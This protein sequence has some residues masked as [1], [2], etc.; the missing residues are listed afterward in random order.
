MFCIPV[1]LQEE[2]FRP[3]Y[4]L[5][6]TNEAGEVATHD[7]SPLPTH[8]NVSSEKEDLPSMYSEKGRVLPMYNE[9]VSTKPTRTRRPKSILV[10]L[11]LIPLFMIW[12]YIFFP[13]VEFNPSSR[14]HEYEE[15]DSTIIASCKSY[16][17]LPSST[18]NNRLS[19]LSDILPQEM[20]WISEP[21]PSTY[22]F[23]GSFSEEEWFLSERPFLISIYQNKIILLTPSFESLR[24]KLI[25]IPEEL[26]DKVEWVEWNEDQSPYQILSDY[27]KQES[28]V[29]AVGDDDDDAVKRF[30]L[31]D[32]V[33]QFIGKG[34]R[35]VMDEDKGDV[36]DE[37][38]KIRERKSD[39][40]KNLL[41]CANQFTLHAIR[42]TRNR[43]YLG[44]TESHT[45][46]ILR[47]EMDKTGLIGGE[48][49][50]LFGENA[51]LPHGSGTDRKLGKDDLVLI[52]AGGKWGGYV[53]DIT[54]TFSLPSS[55]IPKEHIELWETVRL[56]Q[57]APYEL[58]LS[59][60]SSN[61]SNLTFAE[62]D[63][64]AREIVSHWKNRNQDFNLESRS[65]VD[66]D[67]SIFTH[68]LGHGIGLEGHESPYVI[69]GKQGE[70]EIQPGNVFS[71]EPGIYLPANMKSKINGL[72]GIGVRLEDCLIVEQTKQG[73]WKGEW[74]SGPV[75][76]WGDI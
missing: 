54:R 50:V 66:V 13:S 51:A 52:D 48:G 47:E 21:G 8:M 2:V 44:I 68:R 31:D 70:N 34:L 73:N 15:L 14:L 4:E 49:L 5:H 45:G 12:Q 61:S 69:Q 17:S 19:T 7:Q 23:I 40:E 28:A 22:Y 3:R 9:N 76:K 29:G 39:W 25:D 35:D 64:S 11:L 63:R 42:N 57:R 32:G 38:R 75:E 55:K 74:L 33:R 16:L 20:V 26:K 53:S 30:V 71:L 62:L 59:A 56:A 67:F 24:A 72:R 65:D 43:M 36:Q 41:K 46:R 6:Q 58:L 1:H 18:Y 10:K 37:I 27:L 60:N